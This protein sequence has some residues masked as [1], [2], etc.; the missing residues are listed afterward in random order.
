MTYYWLS[1]TVLAVALTLLSAAQG[2]LFW[3]LF[4]AMIVAFDLHMLFTSI[5]KSKKETE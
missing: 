1:L 3:T 2:H 4:G 5:E